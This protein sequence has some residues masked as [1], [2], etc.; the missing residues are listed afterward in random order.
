MV[1][2]NKF[3]DHRSNIEKVDLFLKDTFLYGLRTSKSDLRSLSGQTITEFVLMLSLLTAIG[4]LLMYGLIGGNGQGG[5]VHNMSDNAAR[6]I[7]DVK[8]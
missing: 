4:L 2:N 8:N 7:A 1:S 6:K 3:E 5:A